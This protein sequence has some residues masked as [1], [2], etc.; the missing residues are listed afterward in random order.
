LK[1]ALWAI[2]GKSLPAARTPSPL[3]G[4]AGK[5]VRTKEELVNFF[6]LILYSDKHNHS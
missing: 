4:K 1:I 6:F 2:L 3:W 5:G